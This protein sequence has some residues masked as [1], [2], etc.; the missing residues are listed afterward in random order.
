[1]GVNLEQRLTKLEDEIKAL[2]SSY[3]IYGGLVRSYANHYSVDIPAGQY[4]S[5]RVRFA[6]NYAT[7]DKILVFGF[8]Y[9]ISHNGNI[10]SL[11]DGY[12]DVQ[13]SNSEVI[14]NVS[15]ITGSTLNLTLITPM[16]GTFTRI[17]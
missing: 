17:M 16:P 14:I 3:T 2:K 1:M 6:P 15:T 10:E 7:N 12:I 4:I 5:V 13:G 9:N 8:Y 11:D